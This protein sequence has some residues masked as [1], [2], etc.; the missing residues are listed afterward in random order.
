[1]YGRLD[2]WWVKGQLECVKGAPVGAWPGDVDRLG[3]HKLHIKLSYWTGIW[4]IT[5]G[6]V[7]IK[8]QQIKKKCIEKLKLCN[9]TIKLLNVHLHSLSHIIWVHTRND[10]MVVK[11]W[12]I[13]QLWQLKLLQIL[14]C[15]WIIKLA[16]NITYKQLCDQMSMMF[17]F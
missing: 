11:L 9:L 4:K 6:K 15:E 14:L 5:S 7:S 16:E 17:S 13:F 8:I 3:S 2:M 10:C 12:K 1:M